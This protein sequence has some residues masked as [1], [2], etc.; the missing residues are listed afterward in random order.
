MNAAAFVL[1]VGVPIFSYLVGLAAT[2]F[3]AWYTYGIAG[4]FWLHDSY[5]DGGGVRTW[6]QKWL[7]TTLAVA[8]FVAGAFIC[9]AG[10]YVVVKGI[11]DAYRSGDVGEPFKC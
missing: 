8:T 6:K 1:A 11:V 7:Q 5:H 2:L 10:T 9:V 4:A 3:A